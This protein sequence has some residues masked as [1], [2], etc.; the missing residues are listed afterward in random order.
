[1]SDNSNQPKR[2]LGPIGFHAESK[3]TTI[4]STPAPNPGGIGEAKGPTRETPGKSK[5]LRVYGL[6]TWAVIGTIIIVFG[7]VLLE[8][9]VAIL[10]VMV[11]V[12][13]LITHR[14][15]RTELRLRGEFEQEGSTK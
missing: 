7:L 4:R 15:N 12:V 2:R 1:M 9:V 8:P 10:G 13:A 3:V 6:A 14:S 5:E 11:C